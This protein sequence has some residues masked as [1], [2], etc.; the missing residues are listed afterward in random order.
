MLYNTTKLVRYADEDWSEFAKSGF[1]LV[2][3]S[4]LQGRYRATVFSANHFLHSSR[5]TSPDAT[6]KMKSVRS[7]FGSDVCNLLPF[8][9]KKAI[10]DSKPVLLF[11]SEKT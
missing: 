6:A 1:G 2:K 10:A 5:E 3:G 9:F 8:R 11:P 4:S 7:D